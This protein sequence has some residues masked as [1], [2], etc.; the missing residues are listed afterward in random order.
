MKQLK[1]ANASNR[2]S[3]RWKANNLAKF[4]SFISE[5][6]ETIP[7]CKEDINRNERGAN[8]RLALTIS[9]FKIVASTY[10]WIVE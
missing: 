1:K 3:G 5:G 10:S 8:Y 4:K 7:V 2:R 9:Q 6:I